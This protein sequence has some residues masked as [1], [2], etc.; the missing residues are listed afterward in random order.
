MITEEDDLTNVEDLKEQNSRNTKNYK[1]AVVTNA[2]EKIE[3][4]EWRQET[5]MTH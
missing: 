4:K 5:I 1:S 3:I 2:I